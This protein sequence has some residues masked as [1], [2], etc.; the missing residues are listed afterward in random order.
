MS[1]FAVLLELQNNDDAAAARQGFKPAEEVRSAV[2][3]GWIDTGAEQL[4]LPKAVADALGV[5]TVGEANVRFADGRRD[6][7]PVVGE[8]RLSM[9]GREGVFKAVVEPN[10][11]SALVGAVVLES[12]DLLVDP[13]VGECRNECRPR[14]ADRILAEM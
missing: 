4:V 1:R 9:A 2:V 11:E 7:R 8:V 3:D 10:R 5:P 6:V 13:P 14:D 12:L